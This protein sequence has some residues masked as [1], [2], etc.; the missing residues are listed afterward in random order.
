[1]NNLEYFELENSVKLVEDC[2]SNY[3]NFSIDY[4]DKHIYATSKIDYKDHKIFNIENYYIDN[5]KEIYDN[6]LIE[7]GK[8][9][10]IIGR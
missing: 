5:R 7:N 1:M 4:A 6:F 9:I 10:L 2:L 3:F 8:C